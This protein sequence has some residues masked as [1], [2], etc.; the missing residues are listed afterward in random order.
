MKE[1]TEN[2]DNNFLA[3]VIAIYYRM[4]YNLLGLMKSERRY[5]FERKKR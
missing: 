2:D 1:R 4:N 5:S 3:V